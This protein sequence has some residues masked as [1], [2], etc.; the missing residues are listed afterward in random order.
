MD[1][2]QFEALLRYYLSC[3]DAEEAVQLKLRKNQEYKT[4]IFFE[5]SRSE[6]LFSRN[7]PQLE[8]FISESRQKEFIE[9]KALGT[10]T[11]IDLYYG[12]PV[13]LD[14]KDML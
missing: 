11:L 12:F 6:Q 8:L 5:A 13:Y 2:G 3:L 14:E 9:R 7:L 4:H 10:E 1:Q